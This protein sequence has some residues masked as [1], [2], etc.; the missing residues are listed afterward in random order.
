M[1]R[2][3]LLAFCLVATPALAGE[4]QGRVELV[5]GGSRGPG[6]FVD[7]KRTVEDTSVGRH[8]EET[9]MAGIAWRGDGLRLSAGIGLF[10]YDFTGAGE[11]KGRI[12]SFAVGHE[13]ATGRIGTLS[14]EL[15]HTRMW[16]GEMSLGVTRARLGWS[17]RF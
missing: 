2:T 4:P 3:T 9:S 15:R 14:L 16:E 7:V 12:A 13:L 17:L 10:G 6:L 1:F 5:A 11:G 8:I